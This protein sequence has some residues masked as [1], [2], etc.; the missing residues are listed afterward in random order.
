GNVDDLIGVTLTDSFLMMP[1]K[2]VSGIRFPNE[3][4]FESCELCHREDCPGRRADFNQELWE[5]MQNR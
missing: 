1:N 5:K 2:T 3:V 4:G